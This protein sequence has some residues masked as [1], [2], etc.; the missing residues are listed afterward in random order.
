MADIA[1]TQKQLRLPS[2][3]MSDDETLGSILQ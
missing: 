1:E 2:E 3:E